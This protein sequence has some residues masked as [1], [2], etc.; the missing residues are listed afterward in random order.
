[1]RV[2][3]IIGLI[4]LPILLLSCS[5]KNISKVE[6]DQKEDIKK[7]GVVKMK[8]KFYT[9]DRQ[10]LGKGKFLGTAELRNGKLYVDVTDT[11]L[12][13]LLNSPYQTIKGEKKGAMIVDKAVTLKPGTEEHLKAIA[14]ECWQYGY[15]SEIVDTV[16]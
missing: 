15:I 8:V 2:V 3:K 1:M 5:D 12:K 11:K 7:P 9:I 10:K 13:N 4:L 16:K 14:V 6:Q